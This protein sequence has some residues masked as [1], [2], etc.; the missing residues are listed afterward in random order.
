M[1][2]SF[3]S[4]KAMIQSEVL[5]RSLQYLN[6][7]DKDVQKMVLRILFYIS[8]SRSVALLKQVSEIMYFEAQIFNFNLSGNMLLAAQLITEDVLKKIISLTAEYSS[9]ILR[10]IYCLSENHYFHF[11]LVKAGVLEE[12]FSHVRDTSPKN[13]EPT[14]EMN[15][16]FG[17]IVL[18][19]S[20]I[21]NVS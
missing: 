21:L 12:I 13:L 17:K 7:E 4:R 19:D 11:K 5:I 18:N 14:E 6:S 2:T 9:I 15:I 16:N 1:G 10:I 3:N 20:T 8:R